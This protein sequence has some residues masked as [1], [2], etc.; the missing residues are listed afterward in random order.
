LPEGGLRFGDDGLVIWKEHPW[1]GVSP[2]GYMWWNGDLVMVEIKCPFNQQ[3]RS[4]SPAY[5]AQVQLQMRVVGAVMCDFV[6]W[7]PTKMKTTRI[8]F[9]PVYWSTFLFPRLQVYFFDLLLPNIIYKRKCEAEGIVPV[10]ITDRD[11]AAGRRKRPSSYSS[12]SFAAPPIARVGQIPGMRPPS[13]S[14]PKLGPL[15]PSQDLDL[16]PIFAPPPPPKR[17]CMFRF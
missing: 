6:V 8:P 12:T 4:I 11:L 16:A 14:S 17:P 1:I 3:L 9:D 10:K 2:D 5:Y 13:G 15:V 7:T